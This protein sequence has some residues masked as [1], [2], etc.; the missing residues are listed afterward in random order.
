MLHL[1]VGILI[2]HAS[3]D[4]ALSNRSSQKATFTVED[5][6][7]KSRSLEVGSGEVKSLSTLSR[8][9]VTAIPLGAQAGVSLEIG[10]CPEQ[11]RAAYE[12]ESMPGSPLR[13]VAVDPLQTLCKKLQFS[14]QTTAPVRFKVTGSSLSAEVV[15]QAKG[16]ATLQVSGDL[17]IR[18]SLTGEAVLSLPPGDENVQVNLDCGDGEKCRLSKE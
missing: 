15:V 5:G 13:L 4:I 10:G 11:I 12:N 3:A 2:S 18:S 7:M 9:S 17:K 16:F 8:F 1:V 14:N 6:G